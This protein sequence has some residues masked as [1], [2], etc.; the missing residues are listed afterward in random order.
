MERTSAGV[1]TMSCHQNHRL[2]RFFNPRSI[3]L[4]GASADPSIIRGRLVAAIIEGGYQGHLYPVTRSHQ[5]ILGHTCY[6]SIDRVPATPDL[7]I[8]MV[9]AAVV[10]Q[11]LEA[12]GKKGIRAALILSSGF[13]EQ[14]DDEGRSREA[15]V[16]RIAAQYS[17]VVCGPNAEGF[18]NP[19]GSMTATFSP[20]VHGTNLLPPSSSTSVAIISQSGGVGFAIFNRGISKGLETSFVVSLGN[21]VELECTE[22]IDYLLEENTSAVV[23]LFVEGFKSPQRF[24]QVARRAAELRKPIVVA[25]VG[26]SAAG[27]RASLSHTAT[28]VGSHAV[29][30]SVLRHHGVTQ[31]DDLDQLVDISHV[32]SRLADHPATGKRVAI[33]TASGG[34][35]IWLADTCAASGLEIVNLDEHT[36]DAL[37]ELMPA[38]GNAT[39]PVDITAQGVYTFGFSRPLEILL[40]SPRVDMVIVVTSSIRPEML[41]GNSEAL[42]KVNHATRKPV[43]FCAYTTLHPEAVAHLT[44]GGFPITNSMP[45]AALALSAWADYNAFLNAR[46]VSDNTADHFSE[47]VGQTLA[48]APDVLCEHRAREV[49][50]QLGIDLGP[51]WL[52][53]R[54]SEALAA[55]EAARRPVALKL[56]SPDVLHKTDVGGVQLNVSDGDALK[57][58]FNT[59][60]NKALGLTAS[61][62]IDGVLVQ[63]MALPGVEMIVGISCDPDFGPILMLGLGGVW[64]EVL[65]D[66]QF[67]PVPVDHVQATNMVARLKGAALLHGAR[68]HPTADVEALIDLLVTLSHFADEYRGQIAEVDLNP[69]IV[70]P[71]DGG[72]TIVDA[73]MV[74]HGAEQTTT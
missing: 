2:H 72:L 6:P 4:V 52:A 66:V 33:L 15:E 64:V 62:R 13:N 73:L 61:S 71:L 49:L 34:A 57:S 17:M 7:A 18:Y 20:A 70:H 53:Q 54:E 68:G 5:E 44:K 74:K 24:T 27:A 12:C 48:R 63:P 40:D 50:S 38:Y 9:P 25:K 56:Q 10:P 35:G 46:P 39:N 69:V 28:M 45:N 22:V 14:G 19:A 23:A 43:M 29:Y 21:E 65:A 8:V 42:A 11:L 31:V 55:F 30:E 1:A 47:Q 58:A 3:A 37:G 59:I 36:Q 51:A 26:R 16:G 67:A 41:I 60:M 32:F